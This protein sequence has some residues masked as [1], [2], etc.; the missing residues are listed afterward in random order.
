MSSSAQEQF[1]YT[2]GALDPVWVQTE[3]H[4]DRPQFTTLS[5][6]IQCDV[7]IIGAGISGLSTAYELVNRGKDVVLIE[8]REVLSG[9][10][11]RT[12]GHLSN[13]LDDLYP[14]IK[15]KHGLDGARAAAESHTWAIN[16]VGELSR[17]LDIDCDYRQLPGYR[18]SQYQRGTSEYDADV[19]TIKDDILLASELGIEAE[20]KDDLAVQGW[21][22]KPDQRGGAVFRKQAAFHPTKYLIGLLKWLTAQ[23][24]FRCFT[25]TRAMSVKEKG[26]EILGLGNKHVNIQTESGHIIDCNYAVQATCVPLQKLSVVAQEEYHRTY[27]IAIRTPKGSVEDCLLYDSA[28]PYVYLRT[29]PCDNKDDYLVVGGMDHKVGQEPTEQRFE[30]LESWTRERFTQASSVDYKWSGQIFEPVDYMAFIGKNQGNDHIFII[31]GDSGNGLTHGVLAGKLI[32]DEVDGHADSRW[33]KL[34][35]PKRLISVIKSAP[36]MIAHDLE[37]NAQ[38]KRLLQSDITDIEDL[39]PGTG[40]VLNPTGEKPM[41]VYRDEKGNVTKM[42]AFCPHMKG[43]VCWNQTEKSFDCPVH[44]SRF[45]EK[46]LCVMGPAKGN[47][48]TA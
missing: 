9:E 24:T 15:S 42:S 1:N 28:D 5:E 40:G 34:Y 4:G 29:T 41:A 44:G 43:V 16:R 36:T 26:I 8:A 38:Y 10:T 25:R 33:T 2:S 19:T 21:D 17:E 32:A 22:G 7:C 13:A 48:P 18:V 31:T 14:N 11:S 23:S 3:K 47:L 37:A 35:S 30:A 27:A 45:S 20:W 6:D 12:T 46:G 39:A